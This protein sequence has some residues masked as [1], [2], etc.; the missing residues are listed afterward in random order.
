MNSLLRTSSVQPSLIN[1]TYSEPL[2]PK[3]HTIQILLL[4]M[5]HQYCTL[6]DPHKSPFVLSITTCPNHKT[7]NADCTFLT[8]I[9][10]DPMDGLRIYTCA[11]THTCPSTNDHLF[12][13]SLL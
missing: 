3:S 6:Y 11:S 1:P 12:F 10:L 7:E 9:I 4:S 5:D 13:L 2:L 8:S